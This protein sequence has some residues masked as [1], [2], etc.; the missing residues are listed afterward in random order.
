MAD[1]AKIVEDL[2]ALTVLEAAELSKLLEE[3]WGVSAAAPVAMAMPAGGGAGAPAEAAEEQTEFTVVLIDGG[4]KK[5]NVIK[6]VRGVRSDLG[7]KE[8]KDLVEGAPQNVVENV[9]KQNADEI[10]KKLTE[11]GAKVQIK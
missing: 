2:S 10:A 4:D 9:S 11:A 7:L 6:E 1:L 3:K 8:A 5:I